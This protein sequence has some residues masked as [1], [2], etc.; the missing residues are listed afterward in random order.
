MRILGLANNL[1][2]QHLPMFN[3]LWDKHLIPIR[4]EHKARVADSNLVP[5]QIKLTI[6][7]I[8]SR[9]LLIKFFKK[10][11]RCLIFLEYSVNQFM[12]NQ[13]SNGDLFHKSNYFL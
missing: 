1:Q 12:M 2:L 11:T 4:Q 7:W 13:D 8:S 10:F 3:H 9:L 5:Y 6:L